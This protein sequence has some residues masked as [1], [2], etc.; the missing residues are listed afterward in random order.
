[1]HVVNYVTNQNNCLFY[2]GFS[3]RL[4]R[5]DR[6]RFFTLVFPENSVIGGGTI[7]DFLVKKCY[8]ILSIYIRGEIAAEPWLRQ[9]NEVEVPLCEESANPVTRGKS[10]RSADASE[11]CYRPL[12]PS[13]KSIEEPKYTRQRA[14]DGIKDRPAA[15]WMGISDGNQVV[16]HYSFTGEGTWMRR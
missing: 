6:R 3:Q 11:V 15:G 2:G 7:I 14:Y 9:G 12:S 1:M 10:N 4:L 5:I 13:K 8:Y 16:E